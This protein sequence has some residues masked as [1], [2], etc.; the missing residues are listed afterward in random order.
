MAR[1]AISDSVIPDID[2][3]DWHRG[4]DVE[5][6][7]MTVRVAR[8]SATH[9]W[10]AMALWTVFVLSCVA[11][12]AMVGTKEADGGGAVDETARAEQMIS[13]GDFPA[14]NAMEQILVTSIAGPLNQEAARSALADAASRLRALSEVKAVDQ[15]V[16]SPDG[17]AMM[18]AVSMAGDPDTSDGRVQPL[19]DVTASVARDHP[20]VRVEE[21]G[22]ASIEKGF[23]ETYGKDFARAEMF[24]VPVTL[25]ILLVAFGALIAAGVPIL[26]ALSA[27]GTGGA[28]PRRLSHRRGRDCRGDLWP[29]GRGLWRRGHHRDGRY[30]PGR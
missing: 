10:R 2:S 16:L 5:R 13:S 20:A 23:E 26:L 28:R 24:S 11:L 17:S 6:R 7:P 30:V 29:R 22:D 27:A 3:W 18:L 15:P 8:W 1:G 14:S 12:G 19:L 9:P 21:V 4:N 25:L